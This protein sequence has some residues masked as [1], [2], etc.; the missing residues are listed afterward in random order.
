MSQRRLPGVD[1]EISRRSL[2]GGFLRDA[3]KP[4]IDY[5][6]VTA[7]IRAGWDSC[8]PNAEM[9]R[10]LAP[11]AP[12]IAAAAG[13]GPGD[14]ILDVGAGTGNVAL[15][16]SEA[17]AA[18]DAS[19][20]SPRMVM[21]GL[22]RTGQAIR[23]SQGDAAVLPYDDETFDTVVSAFGAAMAPRARR[24]AKELARVL[25]PGGRLVLGAWAPG[26]LPAEFDRLRAEVDP[27]P[28]GVRLPADWG[29]SEIA[30]ERLSPHFDDLQM[31]VHT[32]E[33][34][35]ES[36]QDCWHALARPLLLSANQR[37]ALRPRFDSLLVAWDEGTEAVELS[38]GYLVVL[39]RRPE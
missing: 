22:E 17:G 39:G 32:A 24:T 38:A 10:A 25:R 37:G 1:G 7:R 19:D 27:L 28:E 6:S 18:V 16:C 31:Q 33:L 20:L 12:V 21:A 30:H 11:I 34:R 9:M 3:I 8:A 14:R 13:A 26:S 29:R 5:D 36:P 35:F 4:E 15:A 23:W 2:F